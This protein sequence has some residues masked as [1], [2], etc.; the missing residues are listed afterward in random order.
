MKK[1]LIGAMV[2]CHRRA[3]LLEEIVLQ[4]SKYWPDQS[5]VHFCMDRPTPEVE[6]K[7]AALV[8]HAITVKCRAYYLDFPVVSSQ[9]ERYM[10]ARNVQLE[11]LHEDEPEYIAFWDDDLLMASPEEAV[12]FIRGGLAD[13]VYAKKLYLWDKPTQ[14]TTHLPE[15][16]SVF[17]FKRRRGDQFP[18]DRIIQAPE[19]LHSEAKHVAQ[20]TTPLLDVGY[21]YEEERRRIFKAYAKAG[22]IDGL[23][24]GLLD[25]PKLVSIISITKNHH[26]LIQALNEHQPRKPA[27]H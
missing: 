5:V 11:A 20:M 23:T 6:A 16:N 12:A 22:K 27:V 3:Y 14:Y 2:L 17:L 4:L 24:Q 1:P 8:R 18:L 9:G 15:H 19:P 13:L 25:Q 21:M 26:N 10:E 7:V